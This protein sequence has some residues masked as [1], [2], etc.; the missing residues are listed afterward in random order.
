M[1]NTTQ[2]TKNRIAATIPVVVCRL[3]MSSIPEDRI[4]QHL[5]WHQ[6]RAKEA[7]Q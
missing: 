5:T 3:C 7:S 6:E 4:A 2:Q 1:S